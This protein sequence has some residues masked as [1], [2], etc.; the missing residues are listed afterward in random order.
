[1]VVD[2]G[3]QF[4]ASGYK[5]LHALVRE[6]GLE[7]AVRPVGRT[8]NAML[9]AGR[10]EP[11]DFGSPAPFLR[12][13]LLSPPAKLRLARIPFEL[14]RHARVLDPLRP[15]RAADLDADDLASWAR[16]TV[17]D[18][19]LEYLLG[20]ALSSTFDSNPEHLSG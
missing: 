4:I 16:R 7:G 5:N 17:G 14:W 18:E 10:L 8:T 12:S 19:V 2:R 20:P 9:R 1:F 15:E 3:A 11:G 6:L 13:K